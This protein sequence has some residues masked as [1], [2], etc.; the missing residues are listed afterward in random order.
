VTTA[1][2][3]APH[4]ALGI[5]Q[6][7]RALYVACVGLTLS[8]YL[9]L[10]LWDVFNYSWL[11]GYDAWAASLYVDSLRFHH[12][13][14]SPDLTAVAHNPPL[15][16]AAA[17]FIED[18]VAWTGLGAQKAVQLLSVACGL[19]VVVLT[20]LIAREVF[21]DRRSVQLGALVFAATTPVLLRGSLMYHPDPLAAALTTGGILIA[22][23]AAARGWSIRSGVGAGLVLGLANLTRNWA[24]A[25][26]VTVVAVA[27]VAWS[28]GQRRSWRFLCAAI[29]SFLLLAG[30][31]YARQTIH[32]GNPLAFD[33]PPSSQWLPA[34]RGLSFFVDPDLREIV[35]NPYRPHAANLLLPVTY[36]DWWGDYWHYFR[37]IQSPDT[38][39]V[40]PAAE[41]HPL[42]TQLLVGLIPTLLAVAGMVGLAVHAV[43]RRD[44]RLG[45]LLGT[46]LLTVLAFVWFLVRFRMMNGSNMKALYIV[47][48]APAVAI[49]AAWS[50]DWIRR[51]SNRLLFGGVVLWLAVMAVYDVSF[52]TLG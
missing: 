12:A 15:F 35:P 8:G 10:Q 40:L 13:I 16:Y 28:L 37:T 20:F 33:K 2:A 11:N 9:T 46:A 14:P 29:V 27:V 5:H 18:H 48:A 38:P 1:E 22:M 34:G 24:A 31:W 51:H 49:A 25:G 41:R 4:P 21:P 52:L 42:V 19:A 39:T 17:A 44:L 32:Y 7:R 3:V 30:P 43:G 45:M 26:I 23:R 6:H 50:L 36:A 47:N